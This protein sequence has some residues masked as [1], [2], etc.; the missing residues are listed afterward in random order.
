MAASQPIR[1]VDL[2]LGVFQ[3]DKSTRLI[4]WLAAIALAFAAYLS[5]HIA[6]AT[7]QTPAFANQF[8]VDGFAAFMKLLTLLATA[9]SILIS[10]GY[11]ER[12]GMA[13]FELPVLM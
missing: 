4:G 5:V 3:G 10:L 7:G 12:N 6:P 1:R 2:I 8:I 11:A 13:R 9:V